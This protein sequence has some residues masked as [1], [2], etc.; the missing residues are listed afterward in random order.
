MKI[1]L[2]GGGRAGLSVAAHLVGAGHAVTL[3]DRD[4]AVT[5][6]AFERYGIVSLTGDASDPRLMHEAEISRADVVVAMLPRDADNLAVAALG[7]E[8]GA[9][10]VMVRVKE[11]AYRTIYIGL[12]V[13][14]IL[15]E[16][17]VFIGALA[18]AIEYEEVRTS[19]LLGNGEAVAFELSLSPTSAAV[20][21]SVSE[22]A[23]SPGF[24]SSCVLAGIYVQGGRV[25]APRGASV[26][27]AGCNVLLVCR[28]SEMSAAI[29][30]FTRPPA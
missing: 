30:F 26:L 21:R 23:A 3:L 11:D 24:P 2:A 28:R 14:R 6:L 27:S 25:E 15:S 13:D 4:P 1:V 8:A 17:D 20:G 12:G 22:L 18:T 29:E 7:R 9:K 5:Q 19:M 16:T 10:R